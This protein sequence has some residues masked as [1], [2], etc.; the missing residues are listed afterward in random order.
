MSQRL[1]L[2]RHFAFRPI[3][4]ISEKPRE[5][6]DGR[7][8]DGTRRIVGKAI[9]RLAIIHHTGG[10]RSERPPGYSSPGTG[11]CKQAIAKRYR[12]R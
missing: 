10:K 6:R 5:F 11:R 7:I 3:R 12:C 1:R 4:R 2:F 8:V 9:E